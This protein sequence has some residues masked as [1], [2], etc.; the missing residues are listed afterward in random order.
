M[1]KKNIKVAQPKIQGHLTHLVRQDLTILPELRDLIPPLTSEEK[2]LLEESILK[3]GIK[4]PIE[5]WEKDNKKIIIDGHNRYN[6]AKKHNL[7][8]ILHYPEFETIEEVKQHM[9]KK[10][11]GRRNLT[12]ANRTYLIGLLYNREKEGKGKYDRKPGSKG[13]SLPLSESAENTGDTDDSKVRNE[14]TDEKIAKQTGTSPKSVRNAGDYADGLNKLVPNLKKG[15]LSGQ[16]KVSKAKVQALGKTQNIQGKPID[17][18]EKID[19]VIGKQN[20]KVKHA[21]IKPVEKHIADIENE[22]ANNQDSKGQSLPLCESLGNTGAAYELTEKIM[23]L[24]QQHKAVDKI[25]IDALQTACQKLATPATLQLSADDVNKLVDD[26][27]TLLRKDDHPSVRIK[28]IDKQNRHWSTLEGDFS[29][30]KA[31]DERHKE[32]LK[33]KKFING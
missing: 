4:E 1:A 14:R 29:T 10:Q 6:I 3:E 9:L 20:L 13:Q 5:V 26:G 24:I 22:N 27:Y 15:I 18:I 25:A 30:K 21:T 17:S 16:K 23:K 28:K 33:D 32:L 2:K 8:F 12:D 7:P 19:K 11:L 31:R